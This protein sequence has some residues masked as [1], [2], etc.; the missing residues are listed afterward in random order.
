MYSLCNINRAGRN[1]AK[2][3]LM[4]AARV[5]R[6][7]T[8]NDRALT[9]VYHNRLKC[10]VCGVVV[11]PSEL[12]RTIWHNESICP[13][14][15]TGSIFETISSEKLSHDFNKILSKKLGKIGE[16]V[17][18]LKSLLKAQYSLYDEITDEAKELTGSHKWIDQKELV[19]G[20]RWKE[21]D[22]LF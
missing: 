10:D 9:F 6:T 18:R 7:S 11:C 3:N 4:E 5:L 21:I 2:G 13:R 20:L 22:F 12:E 19:N 15:L 17:M 16:E 1:P 8:D 14:C